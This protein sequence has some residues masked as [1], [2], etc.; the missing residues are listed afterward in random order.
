[1]N[2]QYGENLDFLNDNVF[3]KK[4][5]SDCDTVKKQAWNDLYAKTWNTFYS[6]A[7]RSTHDEQL[8]EDAVQE[9]MARAH[10]HRLGLLASHPNRK[11]CFIF[12]LQN[13]LRDMA[14]ERRGRLDNGFLSEVVA[15]FTED[16][17]EKSPSDTFSAREVRTQFWECF[18]TLSAEQQEAIQMHYFDNAGTMEECAD[19]LAIPFETFRSRVKSGRKK[20]QDCM[21][22]KE[23]GISP[24]VRARL[25]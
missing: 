17:K 21:K 3:W 20:L 23:F 10:Q 8:A 1:M 9:L 12:I 16:K 2:R 13:E 22:E 6:I 15:A 4:I 19:A 14:K 18:K 25:T 11:A 7:F 5:C 24:S